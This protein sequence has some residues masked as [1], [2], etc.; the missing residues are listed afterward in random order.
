MRRRREIRSGQSKEAPLV[1][2][3]DVVA[4]VE[5]KLVALRQSSQIFL[6]P[7]VSFR[8]RGGTFSFFIVK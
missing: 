2:Q 3:T 8:Q 7:M 4:V 5:E 1:D 6:H